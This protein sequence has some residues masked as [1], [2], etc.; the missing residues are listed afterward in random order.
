MRIERKVFVVGLM[1][2]SVLAFFSV[3]SAQD[4]KKALRVNGAAMGSDQVLIW[5]NEFMAANPGVNIVVTGS[6]AGKGFESL[7]EGLAD[8]AL[9][10]RVIS[11]EEQKKATAKGMKLAN[12]LIGYSGLAI[13]TCS[14]NPINEL[15][16][17]Q[18]RQIF[19]GEQTSWKA[20]GGPD[21]PI[22]CLTRRVPE[23]GGAVFFMEEVMHN[24]PYGK[25]TTF[26]E[27]WGTIMKICSTAKDIPIGIGPAII[28]KGDVKMLGVKQ[29]DN[30]AG[31]KP[32][33]ETVKNRSYP[34][35]NPIRVYWDSRT[36]DERAK[37]FIDYCAE[38]GLQ[39]P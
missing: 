28:V 30:F 18:L 22:R 31:V 11:P 6:S 36:E 15:T 32:S 35:V 25:T 27:S 33:D 1:I 14:S 23:S 9:A 4:T 38:K 3:C 7:F 26:V 16:L 13:V 37:K 24:Q 29:D 17:E 10:S 21:S 8:V 20:V 39:K 34:I 2:L 12:K 5:A 19:S